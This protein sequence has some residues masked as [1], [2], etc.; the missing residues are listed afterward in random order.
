MNKGESLTSPPDGT[1]KEEQKKPDEA[2]VAKPDT[3]SEKKPDFQ[4]HAGG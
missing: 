2:A 1:A 3:Q 4:P